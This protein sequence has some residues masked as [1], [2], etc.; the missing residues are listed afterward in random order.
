MVRGTARSK[1]AGKPGIKEVAAAA[2]VSPTT[3]SRVL[4]NRGY[5]S[6]ETRDKVQAAMKRINYAPND[7]A[8]AMLNG[9]LNLVG[10]IVPFVSNPFHGEVVQ[11]VERTLAENGFKMLLCNSACRPD[12]ERSY[13]DMLRRNMVDGVIVNSLNIGAE[14]Y[15]EM[16]LSLVGI[17]CDLGEGSVQIASDS[18]A[19]G[20]IATRRLIDGGCSRILCLRNNSRMRMPGNKRSEAY[21]DAVA[22]AGLSALVR[23]VEFV[24]SDEEK[25]TAVAQILDENPDIDGIFAGDDMMAAICLNVMA[26]RGLSAPKDI[27]V[28]G[29]DGARRTRTFMPELTTVRQDIERIGELAAQSVIALIN[30]EKPE[31]NIKL[32]VELIEGKTA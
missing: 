23:E 5:I 29:A 26:R 6:Q 27:K 31:S 4:N 10:M 30:G 11:V 28:I 32:P 3:V 9:R 13:I 21:L 18:Y 25:G 20:E 7:I 8:R 17:D 12:L 22:D 15:A 24:K 14:A 19:I 16:G 2:G 1:D